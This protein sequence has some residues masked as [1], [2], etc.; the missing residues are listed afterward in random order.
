MLALRGPAVDD[1]S[2][3]EVVVRLAAGLE[4]PS[5]LASGEGAR[6]VSLP[7][8]AFRKGDGV[9]PTTG[10][11]AV[12]ETG[13]VSFL[14][15]GLLHEEKKSSSSSAGVSLIS[16]ASLPSLMTTSSGYLASG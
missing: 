10:G 9:R 1:R 3:A 2:A 11:V 8:C 4:S 15:A 14:T 5:V 13:G 16:A 6:E 12:R 7:F